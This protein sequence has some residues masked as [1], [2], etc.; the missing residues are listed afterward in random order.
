MC[1]SS[2]SQTSPS[3]LIPGQLG[4]ALS[5]STGNS[6]LPSIL[7]LPCLSLPPLSLSMFIA[8][9]I[10]CCCC[11]RC[12]PDCLQDASAD[13]RCLYIAGA[14]VSSD[15]SDVCLWK[16][17]R[18]HPGD[19]FDPD[20]PD[21]SGLPRRVSREL[22]N[23]TPADRASAIRRRPCDRAKG[24]PRHSPLLLDL[25]PARPWHI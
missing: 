3:P 8:S 22:V 7:F 17:S 10:D 18:Q 5:V 11:W 12:L 1:A 13:H 23:L 15:S 6:P 14:A 9:S 19:C 21:R 25:I 4:R 20:W 2:L 16:L 24:R